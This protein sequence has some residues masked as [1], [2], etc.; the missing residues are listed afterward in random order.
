[1]E[2]NFG[3]SAPYTVGVEEE[4]QLVDPTSLALVPVIEAVLA[5]RDAAGLTEDSV[6]SE[7]SR[8]AWR[9]APQPTERRPNWRRSCPRCA[10][11]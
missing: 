3:A 6:A 7:L 8:P 4:F 11:T 5:A 2:I 10:E 1:M 9:C